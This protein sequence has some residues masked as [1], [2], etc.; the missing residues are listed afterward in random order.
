MENKDFHI[1]IVVLC[2][3]YEE[4]CIEYDMWLECLQI[5]EA[6]SIVSSNKASLTIDVDV[7]RYIFCDYRMEC[8]F[9]EKADAIVPLS[10]FLLFESGFIFE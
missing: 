7:L 3:D 8:F 4:A 1:V 6:A 5:N 2:N 9:E 10:E